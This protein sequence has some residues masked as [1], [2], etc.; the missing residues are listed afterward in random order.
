MLAQS[1]LK[2]KRVL[3]DN[4]SDIK[5]LKKILRTKN[6]VLILFTSNPKESQNTIKALDDAA[7]TVKGEA[8]VIFIDCSLR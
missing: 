5:D 8:T 4:I 6:N 7:E 1:K 3:V 2:Q